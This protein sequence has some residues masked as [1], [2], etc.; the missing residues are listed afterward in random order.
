MQI[1][2]RRDR[3]IVRPDEVTVT[4]DGDFAVV[5]Y[6]EQGVASTRLQ[7]GP[8]IAGMSDEEIID[9]YND[10]LREEAMLAAKYKHVAVE[11]PLGSPQ[12]EYH[13]R[14][15]QWT[16]RGSV[17]RCLIHDDENLQ[18]VVEIDDQE[19][20]LEQFGRLL[21]TYAGWGMRIEFVPEDALHRR[22][23][24]E[25]REPMPENESGD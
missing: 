8:K 3:Y 1:M 23:V 13:A 12:I 21:T 17:L 18:L 16:P 2:K 25:V 20:T 22:P 24:H 11:V 5:E 7:I 14:S 15:D 19:L 6:K 9:L 4:R 10:C